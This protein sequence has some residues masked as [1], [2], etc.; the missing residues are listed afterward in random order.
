MKHLCMAYY[1]FKD[2]HRAE[3]TAM[4]FCSKRCPLELSGWHSL[5][6]RQAIWPLSTVTTITFGTTSA[7]S[8]PGKTYEC[9][10]HKTNQQRERQKDPVRGATYHLVSQSQA[11]PSVPLTLNGL[12]K[13][14]SLPSPVYH[15]WATFHQGLPDPRRKEHTAPRSLSH[16]TVLLV[17]NQTV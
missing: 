9:V 2:L 4:Y 1:T 16:S 12:W 11:L 7:V 8:V 6:S 10:T 3:F 17:F 5:H 13:S 15:R 14:V